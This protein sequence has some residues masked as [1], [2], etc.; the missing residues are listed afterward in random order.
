MLTEKRKYNF[1][2]CSNKPEKAEKE[3]KTKRI[4]EQG[5]Q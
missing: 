2:K 1:I 5:Q 3:Q 4:K